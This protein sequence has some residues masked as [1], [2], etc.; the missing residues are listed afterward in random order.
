MSNQEYVNKLIGGIGR[1]KLATK[2]SNAFPLL[3]DTVT[4]EA[5]TKW[6]QR[7]Y[8]TKRST[9]D[10]SVETEEI[11]D[12]T[13]QK[14]SVTVSVTE[15][16]DLR[17]E[18]RGVNY[19]NGKEL[20]D[21]SLVRYLYAMDPQELPYHNIRVSTEIA[22]TDE[23]F[24][25][26]ISGDNGYD[27]SRNRIVQVYI[28]KEN[29]SID[30]PDDI[31]NERSDVDYVNE[32]RELVFTGFKIL[33]RGI[34]DVETRYYDAVNGQTIS[35]RINK[36]ITITPRLAARPAQSQINN[37]EYTEIVADENYNIRVKMYETGENDLY[38]EYVLQEGQTSNNSGYYKAID[39][40]KIP[41]G[42][43]AYTFVIKADESKGKYQSRILVTGSTDK[44]V[45]NA[46]GTS[47]FSYDVPLVFTIDQETPLTIWGVY[48]S[49]VSYDGC[50]HNTIWDGRGYYNL[51]KGIK[52]DR[53]AKNIFWEDAFM[54]L[55]GTSDVELY[56]LE[57]CNTGFTAIMSKTDP[58]EKNP[59]F[60]YGNFEQKRLCIHHIYVHDTSGEGSYIGY[61][62][63][64]TK[65]I[66]YTGET[67]TFKNLKGEDVTYTNGRQYV[68][69][70]HYLTDMRFYRNRYE[71]TGYDGV[72]ISNAIGEFCY[73]DLYDCSYKDEAAQASGFS[74]QSIAGKVYNNF[75]LDNHGP[76]F[77]IGPL[78]DIEIF[79]NIAQSK[80]GMGV[81]FLF[82]YTT[83]EQNPTGATAGSGVIN[84]DI[85][86]V[87]HNNVIVTP[88]T[89][90]N[91]RNTVQIRGLHLRDNVIANNGFLFTNMTTETIGVW[92]E[93]ALNNE[94][95]LYDNIDQK[96]I[97]LK[98]AD[99]LSGDYRI[100]SDSPLIS[101]GLGSDFVF[102]YRGYKNWFGTIYPIG[103]FMGVYK[104][105]NINDD[106]IALVS[107]SINDGDY[108]TRDAKVKVSLNYQGAATRYRIGESADLTN[109][110]WQNIPAG[111][112]VDYTLSDAFGAKVV[113]CQVNAGNEMSDVLSDS[114]I[115]EATPLSLDSMILNNGVETS[116]S[117][118]IPVVFTY[119]GSNAP[120]KYRLS[121]SSAFTGATWQTM[122]DNIEYM[123]SS[124]GQ[125]T[126]YGQ[127]QDAE[128]NETEIK[129]DDINIE[130]L[131]VRAIVS[132]GWNQTDIPNTTP[133]LSIYD[134]ETGITRF[135]SQASTNSARNI[136]DILG[137]QLLGTAV[138]SNNASNMVT[139]TGGEG[140][141]TGNNSGIFADE[142]LRHNS[143]VGANS[144]KSESITFTLP[145]GTYKVRLLA[146]TKWNQR[147]IPNEA[148]SY[149]A[150]TDTDE[151][152][153]VLPETGVQDN[154]AN[155]TEPVTVTVGD[156]G[157]LRIEFGISAA[158]MFYFAPLNVIEI[159]KV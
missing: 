8:F 115:Y 111:G 27:T 6:A 100:A 158:G 28:L 22:R 29:G 64:E 2:V 155:M 148:L 85:Q 71:H 46:N 18:V 146:N 96:S 133:G 24:D 62:T 112:I 94:V 128:G 16:G 83:P 129:S 116:R 82:S 149:K 9:P 49:T 99:Y 48:Y 120:A 31:V 121:E 61:F 63:P 79:N 23:F 89:A 1:V 60:W 73:N 80:R 109:E 110:P 4:L 41:A 141:I 97:D 101:S 56:E 75:L 137:K 152:A 92:E 113:Y 30:N 26:M 7:M 42:K 19:R 93:Q 151:V 150:V 45:S 84:D 108:T 66:T 156:T 65:T 138:P 72:Q 118:T 12:N 124:M 142:Y 105:P 78:G 86:M 39:I 144:V 52:F 154:T 44:N 88:G 125:K 67:T 153:F 122:R 5:A 21:K 55:N 95:F 136:Y 106:P 157:M 145:A 91:G 119:S 36:L 123:F 135:N 15:A 17:Q 32:E 58:T 70:A 139:Q 20:F 68:R 77:Q 14:T 34:Y 81:Q 59:Q 33:Q 51:E 131:S 13:S 50:I 127:L 102:D 43:D 38:C 159:E 143:A 90:M 140:S 10:T 69:K 107:I 117:L 54:L 104:S 103:A 130:E 57:M 98:I 11:I 74:L 87:F 147:V 37:K 3:G 132:I 134:S 114:I 76:S 53:F 25:L 47:Q 40:S 126:L 35:K